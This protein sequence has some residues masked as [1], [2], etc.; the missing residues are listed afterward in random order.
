MENTLTACLRQQLRNAIA[1]GK[2]AK[3]GGEMRANEIAEQQIAHTLSRA[4]V[5]ARLKMSVASV[6]RLE[7]DKL[8]PEQDEHG[9]W[10]FDPREVDAVAATKVRRRR[11]S[12][13]TA[14]CKAARAQAR[15]GRLAADVFR[16][17]AKRMTLPQIVVATGQTP[18]AIRELY[19]QWS[20]SLDDGEWERRDRREL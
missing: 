7:F 19:H 11:R 10:R 1:S 13:Q 5:A 15:E 4:D 16:C 18:A 2:F 20:T 8:H 12:S 3:C 14:Q 17:F 9:V 6:R